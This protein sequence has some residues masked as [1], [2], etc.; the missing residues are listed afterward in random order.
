MRPFVFVLLLVFLPLQ[1]VWGAAASYCGH[2]A[3]PAAKHFGHHQHKHQPGQGE[4]G[5]DGNGSAKTNSIGDFDC[6]TCHLS[7]PS[8]ASS[9]VVGLVPADGPPQFNYH[10]SDLSHIPAG[11]ERPD[12]ALA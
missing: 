10:R 5:T 4:R 12:R 7:S 3:D 9:L 6:A 2:E 8:L 11:P 1:A